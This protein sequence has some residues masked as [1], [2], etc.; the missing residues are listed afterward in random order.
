MLTYITH[1]SLHKDSFV[2]TE[3]AAMVSVQVIVNGVMTIYA[4]KSACLYPFPALS[5][6]EQ[7]NR[8]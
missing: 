1:N 6:K 7:V 8:E 5:S 4:Y 2:I 3:N